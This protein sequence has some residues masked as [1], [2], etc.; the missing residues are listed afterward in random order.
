MDPLLRTSIWKH[1]VA[2]SNPDEKTGKSTTI[3]ITTHYIEEAIQSNR[4]GMMRSGKLLEEGAPS[5]LLKKYNKPNLEEVFLGLCQKDGDI[6]SAKNR[7]SRKNRQPIVKK[8]V[9]NNKNEESLIAKTDEK[10]NG[11]Q[12][13]HNGSV[14]HNNNDN[15]T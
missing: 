13:V 9:E 7:D 5:D 15:K 1:L 8:N 12:I 4:V 14:K 3:V 6:E 11:V 10:S 2:M